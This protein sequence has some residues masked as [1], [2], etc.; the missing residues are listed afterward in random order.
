LAGCAADMVAVCRGSAALWVGD[1][2][3]ACG[4]MMAAAGQG[5]HP[6]CTGRKG[7]SICGVMWCVVCGG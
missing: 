2:P 6:Q 7:R 4:P 5:R 3:L 1:A